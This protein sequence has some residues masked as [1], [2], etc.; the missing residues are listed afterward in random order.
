MKLLNEI[1][2]TSKRNLTYNDIMDVNMEYLHL[3]DNVNVG[4]WFSFKL[5][6]NGDDK[7][8]N[9]HYHQDCVDYA[10]Q[11]YQIREDEDIIRDTKKALNI[12]F[13]PIGKDIYQIDNYTI[14]CKHRSYTVTE[15]IKLSDDIELIEE[16]Y[17]NYGEYAFGFI[18]NKILTKRDSV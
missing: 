11:H 13:E 18:I 3:R 2:R 12:E 9:M 10:L 15:N 7:L 6:I 17:S 4:R 5:G 1:G 8:E 14:V 16:Y